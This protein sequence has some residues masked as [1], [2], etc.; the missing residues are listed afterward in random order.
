MRIFHLASLAVAGLIATV[1]VTPVQAQA[2]EI[3]PAAK[4]KRDKYVILPD[5]IAEHPDLIDG[6]DVVKVLRNQWLRVT[7]GSGRGMGSGSA[8]GGTYTSPKRCGG[9][10]GASPD[11]N[12]SGG[13]GSGSVVPRESGTPYAESSATME[14]AGP[15]EPVL[16][17]DDVKQVKLDQLKNLRVADIAEIRF[18][19]GNQ[20]S[21]RYGANHEAGAILVKMVKFNQP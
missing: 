9:E 16:Y 4:V 7:R 5:E 19:T 6:Y 2:V 21:G 17:V 10:P 18:L 15:T 1:L 3:K 14:T 8:A 20:A 11:P 12:C 13:G